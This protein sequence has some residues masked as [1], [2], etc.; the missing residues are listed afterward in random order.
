MRAIIG[1]PD[2]FI[3][4]RG[5]VYSKARK[6]GLIE[7][8]QSTNQYGY[9]TIRLRKNGFTYRIHR[10]VLKAFDRMPKLGEICRHLD[11]NPENNHRSNLKWGTQKE[12]AQDCL[13]HGRNPFQ[14]MTGEKSP[15]CKYSD[16]EVEEIRQWR[17]EGASYKEIIEMY[18]ISKAQVSYIVNRKTRTQ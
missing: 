11:G 17:E 6:K 15:V 2:F 5:D 14:N 10:E 3:S 12:N 4:E 13:R 18:G 7:R 1:E 8:K 9:K 16:K